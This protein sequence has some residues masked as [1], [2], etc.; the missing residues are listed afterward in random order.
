[1]AEAGQ[2]AACLPPAWTR[3]TS[4]TQVRGLPECRGARRVS[5]PPSCQARLLNR[6]RPRGLPPCTPPSY[7]KR[8]RVETPPQ[9]R[10]ENRL[11]PALRLA[12]PRGRLL[13]AARSSVIYEAGAS[14]ASAACRPR[15]GPGETKQTQRGGQEGVTVR[16]GVVNRWAGRW[17]GR[18]GRL[19]GTRPSCRTRNEVTS[20]RRRQ[21]RAS[22]SWTDGA[23]AHESRR[24]GA[25][26]VRGP[27]SGSGRTDGRAEDPGVDSRK[28]EIMNQDPGYSL[29][30]SLC[31]RGQ[32]SRQRKDN[33]SA[34]TTGA[35]LFRQR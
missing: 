5:T 7:P 30:N 18:G 28:L 21:V 10:V 1:M 29:F 25:R 2:R 24:L 17:A 4:G 3:A 35:G 23:A 31:A 19:H 12:A 33:V 13:P 9:P 34:K 14:R 20:G 16:P 22:G 15:T 26:R 11:R 32:N 27:A 8:Q 6:R